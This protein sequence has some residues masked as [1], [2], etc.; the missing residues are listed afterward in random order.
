MKFTKILSV[1]LL[2]FGVLFAS[3]YWVTKTG[4]YINGKS[5]SAYSSQSLL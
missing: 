4:T 1:I 3:R 2:T 5:K